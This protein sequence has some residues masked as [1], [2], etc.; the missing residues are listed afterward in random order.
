MGNGIVVAGN[1]HLLPVILGEDVVLASVFAFHLHE[2]IGGGGVVGDVDKDHALI[3][4]LV[5]HL[6]H[7]LD[8]K[9]ARAA[10]CGPEIDEYHFAGM[11]GHDLGEICF[12]VTLWCP[13][14]VGIKLWGQLGL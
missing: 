5:L 2:A 8:S 7:F 13:Q 6:F 1:L 3:F 10:P 11:T 14:R 9:V 4:Q 12:G